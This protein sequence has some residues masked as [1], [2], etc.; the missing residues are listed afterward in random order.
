MAPGS[1][2]LLSRCWQRSP[3]K[4]PSPS[5]RVRRPRAT[6]GSC[7][8]RLELKG[9][10]GGLGCLRQA[11]SGVCKRSR[12]AGP[13]CLPYQLRPLWAFRKNTPPTHSWNAEIQEIRWFPRPAPPFEPPVPIRVRGSRGGKVSGAHARDARLDVIEGCSTAG[14][15]RAKTF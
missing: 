5:Q 3:R 6:K 8:S 9:S 15:W 14:P 11:W 7:G 2:S 4:P 10:S 13:E 12:P 1:S